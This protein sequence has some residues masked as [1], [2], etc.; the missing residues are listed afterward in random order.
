MSTTAPK[1]GFVSLGCPIDAVS[2][3]M[4]EMQ[5]NPDVPGFPDLSAGS[6]D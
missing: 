4:N 3:L 1:V 5:K 6:R 2:I